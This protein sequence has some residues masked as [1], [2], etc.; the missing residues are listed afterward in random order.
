MI[1]TNCF[2]RRLSWLSV[3]VIGMM[4]TAH[5]QDGEV[6]GHY[7]TKSLCQAAANGKCDGYCEVRELECDWSGINYDQQTGE[8]W[9]AWGCG[10]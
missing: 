6:I 8:C 1:S 2:G 7:Q 9:A 10:R 5:T 3:L 4:T